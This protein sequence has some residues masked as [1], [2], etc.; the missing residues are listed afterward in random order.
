MSAWW[1][2]ADQV[3]KSAPTGEFLP[4]GS[5]MIRG[6]KNFLP[7]APLLLGFGVLFQI[8]EESK[9]K[10]VKHRVQDDVTQISTTSV[11]E[12][13]AKGDSSEVE[14]D[15]EEERNASDDDEVEP[16]ENNLLQTN[17]SSKEESEDATPPVQELEEMEIVAATPLPTAEPVEPEHADPEDS[18]SEPESVAP[19]TGTQTP[20]TKKGPAPAKR[21]KKGKAK[22]LAQKYK[23]QDEEDRVAAQQLLGS[24]AGQKK[25]VEAAAAKEAREAEAAFQKERRRAQHQRTQQET[26]EHEEI[27]RTMLE[28]GE[29]A[30]EEANQLLLLDALVGLPLRG[31]EILE[32]IPVCAPY[33][34]MGQYKYKVKLQPGTIKKGKAVKEILHKWVGDMTIKG[35]VDESSADPERMWPREVELLKGWKLEEVTNTVPVSRVRVMVS[36]GAMGTIAEKG[37]GGSN[38]GGRGGKGGKRR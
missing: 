17:P 26:A 32:A 19:T 8:S 15:S 3:S 29:T 6:K 2:N 23:D 18:D 30:E 5:F 24:T 1:V 31:D 16:A 34:A 14:S 13:T 21:G 12:V 22:K 7:P 36:G 20:S 25:A 38:K 4:T 28:S 35:K 11:P 10:H 37:K 33:A 27:R 9:A